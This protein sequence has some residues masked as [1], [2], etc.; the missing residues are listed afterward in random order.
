MSL[1]RGQQQQQQTFKYCIIKLK[2]L[3]KPSGHFPFKVATDD[4]K[5]FEE[6]KH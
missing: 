1:E 6:Y 5:S 2:N 3:F 4:S